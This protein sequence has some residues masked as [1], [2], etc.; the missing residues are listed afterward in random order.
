M[1]FA[2]APTFGVYLLI[3]CVLTVE[4]ELTLQV[5][6]ILWLPM[7]DPGSQVIK[8][9]VLLNQYQYRIPVINR[10]RSV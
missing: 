7:F 8:E 3:Y 9:G 4:R 5:C 2:V 10:I 6:N 1:P